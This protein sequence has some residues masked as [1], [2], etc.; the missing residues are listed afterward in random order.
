MSVLLPNIGTT[1]CERAKALVKEYPENIVGSFWIMTWYGFNTEDIPDWWI[2]IVLEDNQ[3]AAIIEAFERGE[4]RGKHQNPLYL[5][6]CIIVVSGK[7]N[8]ADFSYVIQHLRMW[9]FE[10]IGLLK[11]M[12]EYNIPAITEVTYPE[13]FLTLRYG[14]ED[15][16]LEQFKKRYQFDLETWS[17]Q[18]W[19]DYCSFLMAE[20]GQKMLTNFYRKTNQVKDKVKLL[21]AE[22]TKPLV[23]TEGETDPIYIKAALDLLRENKILGSVDIE[24]VG[25][26]IGT[27]KSINTGDDG[28]NRTRDVLI[29]NPKFLNRKVLLLYDCDT[30]RSDED[31]NEHLK[32]RRIPKI[33]GRK[34]QKGIENLFPDHLFKPEFYVW[35]ETT[36]DY[37]EVKKFQEFQKMKFCKWLCEERRNPEDFKDFKVIVDF[38]KTCLGEISF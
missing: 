7:D 38:I 31:C 10:G 13:H 17:V 34:V 23:L 28:L 18:V 2:D 14:D 32:I 24:W 8:P 22:K 4:F 6:F 5:G 36:G 25:T 1:I 3:S 12:A 26:S 11:I 27:G 35:R 15:L 9:E 21:V 33:E 16:V 20:H 29:S 30:K 37:G 19:E